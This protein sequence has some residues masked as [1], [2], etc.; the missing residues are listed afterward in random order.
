MSILSFSNGLYYCY[1]FRQSFFTLNYILKHTWTLSNAFRCFSMIYS[2]LFALYFIFM[3]L[4]LLQQTFYPSEM[5]LDTYST[6]FHSFSS[7]SDDFTSG[8]PS[9]DEHT[10]KLNTYFAIFQQIISFLWL[11]TLTSYF[12]LYS[13]MYVNHVWAFPML[14]DIFPWFSAAFQHIFAFYWIFWT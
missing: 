8:C 10:T 13:R 11:R 12:E 5:V 4:V 2:D 3:D 1:D 9:I 14:S 7:F 6:Y